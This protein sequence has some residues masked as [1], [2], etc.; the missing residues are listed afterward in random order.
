VSIW[1]ALT[2]FDD[3]NRALDWSAD[4]TSRP[5]GSGLRSALLLSYGFFIFVVVVI[6]AL[7][8]ALEFV[9]VAVVIPLRFAGVEIVENVGSNIVVDIETLLRND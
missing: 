5:D 9:N 7:E 1:I 2:L 3:G 6:D 8:L 4:N